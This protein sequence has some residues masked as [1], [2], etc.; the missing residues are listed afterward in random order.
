MR[1]LHY[2]ELPLGPLKS[3]EQ[4]EGLDAYKPRGLWVSVEGEYDWYE[5]ASSEDFAQNKFAFCSEIILHE[6]ANILVLDTAEAVR[7]LWLRYGVRKGSFA[8]RLFTDAIAWSAIAKHWQGIIITPYQWDCRM[9][10]H[11]SWYYPWD[12]ASGCIW[13]ANAIKEVIPQVTL[14]TY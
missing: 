14:M 7:S 6:T 1:L 12:C 4:A 5:W 11:C 9:D 2:S 8:G 3:R 13:D 10:D